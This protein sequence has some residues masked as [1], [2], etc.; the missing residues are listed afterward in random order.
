VRYWE[1]HQPDD[2]TGFISTVNRARREN[3]ALQRTRNLRFHAVDN[4]NLLCYSKSSDDG[5]NVIFVVV[6]M[7]YQATQSGWVEFSPAAVGLPHAVPFTVRDLLTDSSY[8]WDGFWN[9]VRLDPARS[10]VH[11]FR[12]ER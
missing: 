4:P 7:D 5:S 10:P 2:L 11:L 1:L 9:F 3:T 6:N 12:L 8:S